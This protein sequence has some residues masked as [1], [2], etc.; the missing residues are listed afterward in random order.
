MD[1]KAVLL[2]RPGLISC[3]SAR[4]FNNANFTVTIY[5]TNMEIENKLG[6]DKD[7]P[8]F[9]L[10][11]RGPSAV[12]HPPFAIVAHCGLWHMAQVHMW[13]WWLV[14]FSP[15]PKMQTKTTIRG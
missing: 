2:A 4:S 13:P 14:V 6:I 3:A 12:H 8:R 5:I 10:P 7:R 1:I 11:F 15:S 9:Y